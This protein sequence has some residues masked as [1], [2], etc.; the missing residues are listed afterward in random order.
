M[1]VKTDPT[2]TETNCQKTKEN[3]L[4]ALNDFSHLFLDQKEE[5]KKENKSVKYYN[6]NFKKY[7][8]ILSLEAFKVHINTPQTHIWQ[9]P[10]FDHDFEDNDDD[11]EDKFLKRAEQ[12]LVK[13]RPFQFFIA[14][15]KKHFSKLHEQK[16]ERGLISEKQ[17]HLKY[18]LENTNQNTF[19]ELDAKVPKGQVVVETVLIHNLENQ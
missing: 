6:E 7:E 16:L 13:N 3:P 19:V 12:E 14:N 10:Y 9:I 5:P 8:D 2:N 15:E 18:V 11:E 17:D 1:D 4:D